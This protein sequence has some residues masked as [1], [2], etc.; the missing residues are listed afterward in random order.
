LEHVINA[1]DPVAVVLYFDPI[2]GA[3]P[4]PRKAG[5]LIGVGAVGE[6]VK[7]AIRLIPKILVA[8]VIVYDSEEITEI[9][10]AIC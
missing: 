9:L 3:S 1:T 8:F 2:G 5:D 6:F 7:L 4:A 10:L